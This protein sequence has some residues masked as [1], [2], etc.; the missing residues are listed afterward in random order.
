[1]RH[2]I[3]GAQ[4]FTLIELLLVLGVLALLLV[5]MFVIYPTVRTE[6]RANREVA[7][8]TGVL[9]RFQTQFPQNSYRGVVNTW[10]AAR[11]TQ[12]W[13]TSPN[14]WNN[15]TIVEAQKVGNYPQQCSSGRCTHLWV[16]LYYRTSEMSQD[17]CLKIMT[18]LGA[19]LQMPGYTNP[20]PS[21]FIS[22]CD[23]D[24][25]PLFISLLTQ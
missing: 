8:I 14:G 18:K 25:G 19:T 15:W 4:G 17:E 6:M 13:A 21:T 24:S 1:M 10:N 2:Q 12:E 7:F 16:Q 3:K 5:A 20:G 11:G 22:Q 9:A 23:K